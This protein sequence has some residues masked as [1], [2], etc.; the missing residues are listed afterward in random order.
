MTQEARPILSPV[1]GLFFDLGDTLY[2]YLDV[3]LSWDEHN[4][5]ALIAAVSS[6]DLILNE[7]SIDRAVGVL[8]EFNTR[9]NPREIELNQNIYL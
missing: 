2:T 4:R 5:P 6:C 9:T 7:A 8:G 1:R 3:P